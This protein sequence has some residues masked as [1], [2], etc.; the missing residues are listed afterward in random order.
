MLL[1]F[2]LQIVSMLTV[3]KIQLQAYHFFNWKQKHGN[4]YSLKI[5]FKEKTWMET[6]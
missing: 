1:A 6:N 3:W 2:V 5:F 4:F